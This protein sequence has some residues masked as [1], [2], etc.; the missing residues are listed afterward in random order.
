MG[1]VFTVKR[2]MDFCVRFTLSDLSVSERPI[3]FAR[4]FFELVLGRLLGVIALR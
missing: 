1:M 3:N 4:S 2:E